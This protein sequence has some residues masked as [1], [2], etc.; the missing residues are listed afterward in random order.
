[1]DDYNKEAIKATYFTS[2]GTLSAQTAA[3]TIKALINQAYLYQ[4][5]LS[6]TML[7]TDPNDVAELLVASTPL[8]YDSS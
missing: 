6:T 3:N 7:R 2:C 8:R 1:M 5:S 4:L